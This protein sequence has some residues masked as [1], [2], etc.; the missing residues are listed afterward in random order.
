MLILVDGPEKAGKTTF[1]QALAEDMKKLG[2]DVKVVHQGPWTPDDS[3]IAEDV[4][5]HSLDPKRWY[6]WDRGWP[7]ETVYASLLQRPRRAKDNPFLMEWLHGRS[8]AYKFLLFPMES[9]ELRKRRDS[10]D[11]P[12]DPDQEILHFNKF[13]PYGYRVLYNVYNEGSIKDNIQAVYAQL[14]KV[15]RPHIYGN[16]DAQVIFVASKNEGC[17]GD[18]WLPLS[19]SAAAEAFKETLGIKAFKCAYMFARWGSPA[20]LSKD[21]TIVTI[22]KE[23]ADWVHFYAP[24]SMSYSNLYRLSSSRMLEFREFLNNLKEQIK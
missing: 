16:G 18:R 24:A 1:C 6:I 12:V 11:L 4:H 14:D 21:K 22:G 7:S 3:I 2:Y 20:I 13:T 19:Y 17:K 9:G 10:T 8:T 23:A 5:K 15:H